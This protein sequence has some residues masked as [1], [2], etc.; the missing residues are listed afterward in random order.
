MYSYNWLFSWQNKNSKENLRVDYYLLL[1]YC[2]RQC[3]LLPPTWAKSLTIK[4]Y[5]HLQSLKNFLFGKKLI[6][7]FHVICY[8]GLLQSKILGT[9]MNWRSP[10]KFFWRLFFLENTCACVLGRWPWPRAYLSLASRGS[11]LGKL[12]LGIG[13]F[14]CPWPWPRACVLDSTSVNQAIWFSRV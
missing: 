6:T 12:V 2:M 4:I 14:L 3:I 10:E 11:V 13:F 9:P 8:S 7:S 5:N 1:K